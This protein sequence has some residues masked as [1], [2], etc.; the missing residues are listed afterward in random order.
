MT[1]LRVD[2]LGKNNGGG[3]DS[4]NVLVITFTLTLIYY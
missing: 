3:D 4:I 1:T 2:G